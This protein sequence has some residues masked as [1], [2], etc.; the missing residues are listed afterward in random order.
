M[1][2]R[3]DDTERVPTMLRLPRTLALALALVLLVPAVASAAAVREYQIQFAPVTAQGDALAIVTAIV[4][5]GES[6][7]ASV[8]VPVPEGATLLWAGEILGGDPSADP[9]RETTV[10]R[11][12]DMDLYTFTLEQSY[13]GQVEI[14]LPGPTISGSRLSASMSWTN[15]GPEVLVTGA[16]IVEPGAA[17]VE[18][19]PELVGETQSNEIGERLFP[20]AGLRLAEGGTYPMSVEWSRGGGEASGSSDSTLALLIGALVAAVVALIA[21][22]AR[23]RTKARRAALHEERGA[24]RAARVSATDEERYSPHDED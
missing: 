6:L 5:P 18:T 20:L 8:T 3:T 14:Q 23:E 24:A 16:I 22:W 15:P 11:V 1:A 13:T 10:E 7:P 9:A 2:I 17:D 21:V 12:G 4:D 19:T